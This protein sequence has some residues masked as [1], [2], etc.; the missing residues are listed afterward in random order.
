ML[1]LLLFALPDM[2]GWL[3]AG[4]KLQL[5]FKRVLLECSGHSWKVWHYVL[6]KTIQSK[7]FDDDDPEEESVK[8]IKQFKINKAMKA[9]TLAI[10]A[11]CLIGL[12]SEGF[13]PTT[14]ID[15]S[16]HLDWKANVDNGILT[17][18]RLSSKKPR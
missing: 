9:L 7:V 17:S 10:L 1:S 6:W 12:K 11:S 18:T 13:K 16:R 14:M 8:W 4:V 5:Y 15:M 2:A 3:L